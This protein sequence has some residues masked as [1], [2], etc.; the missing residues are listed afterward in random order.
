MAQC[1]VAPSRTHHLTIGMETVMT[2][3]LQSYE[4]SCYT[5]D[6]LFMFTRRTQKIPHANPPHASQP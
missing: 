3:I 6:G 1:L 2:T 5:T 4:T